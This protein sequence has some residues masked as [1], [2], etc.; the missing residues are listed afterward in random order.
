MATAMPAPSTLRQGWQKGRVSTTTRR[1]PAAHG[2]LRPHR[3]ARVGQH[4]AWTC[5]SRSSAQENV[6]ARRGRAGQAS[7]RLHQMRF[8]NGRIGTRNWPGQARQGSLFRFAAHSQPSCPVIGPTRFESELAQTHPH[9]HNNNN[10]RPPM[11]NDAESLGRLYARTAPRLA[12]C[13]D[14]DARTQ[15]GSRSL[16][17]GTA[18][19]S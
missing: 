5:R 15:G 9:T 1:A 8:E 11:V 10:K 6:Q 14:L 13:G 3:R 18:P 16:H 12:R 4:A 17:A 19:V 2:K 7:R